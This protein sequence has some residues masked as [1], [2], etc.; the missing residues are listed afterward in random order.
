MFFG[1]AAAFGGGVHPWAAAFGVN[2]SAAAWLQ[3][4]LLS[5]QI[6]I[7][8]ELSPGQ[9]TTGVWGLE[10][11]HPPEAKFSRIRSQNNV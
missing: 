2:L 11:P 3:P 6:M 9:L 10:R 7:C 1:G 5:E 8:Q 4:S